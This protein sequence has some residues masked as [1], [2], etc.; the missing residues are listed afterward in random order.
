MAT[1]TA[2][3]DSARSYLNDVGKSIWTDS[4]LLPYLKEAHR[5]LQIMLFLNGIP[6]LKERSATLQVA[7]GAIIL[8]NQPADLLEPIL[9][10][11]RSSGSSEGWITMQEQDYESDI[12]QMSS[13]IY[14]CWREEAINFVGATTNR[15]VLLRYWKGLTLP[16]DENS[17]LGFIFAEVFLGPQA[18]GYAAKAVGNIT[19]AAE[20]FDAAKQ[21]LDIIIRANIKG[22]QGRSSRR[23]PYRRFSRQRMLL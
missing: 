21:K 13:L 9:M 18:A 1:A 11:E 6:V 5:D 10:K 19:L 15:E 8:A 3:L 17:I 2:A 23:V 20:N 22:A 7:A 4:V 14:W 16:I 12:Q